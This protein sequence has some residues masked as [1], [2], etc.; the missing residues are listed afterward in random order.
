MKNNFLLETQATLKRKQLFLKNNNSADTNPI[1][2]DPES[3]PIGSE[4]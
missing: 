3:D 4:I 1:R 2:T